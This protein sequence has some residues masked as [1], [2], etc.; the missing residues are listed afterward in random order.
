M[1]AC[2]AAVSSKTPVVPIAYSRKFKGLFGAIGSPWT[3]DV[4]GKTT[5]EALEFIVNAYRERTTLAVDCAKSMTLVDDLHERYRA[6]LRRFL[7]TT[8]QG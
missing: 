4:V 6:E 1:H 2:I 7:E 5:E 8:R 3:I